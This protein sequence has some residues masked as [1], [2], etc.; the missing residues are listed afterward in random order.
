[1]PGAGS[2]GA[3]GEDLGVIT[4]IAPSGGP[5]GT[6]VTITGPDLNAAV[7]V[8]FGPRAAAEVRNDS[9]TQLSAIAPPGSGQVPVMVITGTEVSAGVSFAYTPSSSAPRKGPPSAA[10]EGAA[11]LEPSP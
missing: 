6:Q 10:C 2:G 4:S 9:S 7:T 3:S 1:M 5:P 11:A 8:C